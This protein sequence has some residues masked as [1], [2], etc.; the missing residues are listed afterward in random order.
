MYL[1]HF[2]IRELPF[3]LTPNTSY[4]F[5]L[6]SHNEAM[7]VLL[8]ALKTGEGF[9]KVTGEVGTGKTLICRKLL[10][11]LPD[12]F[13]AA[14]VPNPML[15]P[16]ELRR[17]VANE[18]GVELGS[19]CDQ[20]AF[21]QKIQ[22]RLIAI[23][24]QQKSAVLI[25]DEAQAL[26]IESIEALR[27]MTNLET[28][29]R[30]LLQVV[31]FGQPELDEKLALPEL[32]QLRQRI[33]FSYSLALMDPDQVYQ[34]VRHRVNVAGY[35][36]TDLFNRQCCEL[37]YRASAGTP[38]MV[39]VLAHKALML[40]YGE[41]KSAVEPEHIAAASADTEAA[42]TV[43]SKWWFSPQSKWLLLATTVVVI[44]MIAGIWNMRAT[45]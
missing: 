24:Q 13:V 19:D 29:S 30:K 21:T 33:T 4:F 26:P 15:S 37:L 31:L 16:T 38:R 35:H 18:L 17:A 41:G 27:L 6:P 1:Y 22:Q 8:T 42:Q 25:I 9:I 32:R 3:T 2:G 11:E 23:H 39:N 43:S 36:G 20:Q 10:N 45:L 28:E 5:G 44:A 40:A 7:Q 14:Y 34:Y 12:Y